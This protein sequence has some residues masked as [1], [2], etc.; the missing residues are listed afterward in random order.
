M[1]LITENCLSITVPINLYC[2]N[3]C[4]INVTNDLSSCTFG[5][6]RNIWIYLLHNWIKG[7]HLCTYWIYIQYDNSIWYAIVMTN[8]WQN[9]P[10]F[11]NLL[12]FDTKR[13]AMMSLVLELLLIPSTLL[14][15]CQ[16]STIIFTSSEDQLNL[17]PQLFRSCSE[18]KL[19]SDLYTS[20]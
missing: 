17:F 13:Q 11:L 12:H 1:R 18:K 10:F 9:S 14:W 16:W 4:V 20:T 15:G 2:W 19:K 3:K 6:S 7:G 5:W 8:R